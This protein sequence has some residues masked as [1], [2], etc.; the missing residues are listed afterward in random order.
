MGKKK[1][2]KKII[3]KLI[4]EKENY[5]LFL[6][7]VLTII[8]GYVLM[9]MGDTYSSLSLTI[10]PIILFV[11]YMV[12]VPIAIMYRKKEEANAGQQQ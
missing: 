11:G 8:L 10:A 9:A 6:G 4:F 1:K 12:I 7:G 3:K 2:D 5:F